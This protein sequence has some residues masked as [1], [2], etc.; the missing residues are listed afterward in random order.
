MLTA[1]RVPICVPVCEESLSQ[2]ELAVERAAAA[3]DLIEL[4][5]D[6]LRS[7]VEGD[8]ATLEKLLASEYDF[9]VTLRPVEQGGVRELDIPSRLKFWKSRWHDRAKFLDIE[10]DLCTNPALLRHDEAPD[11]SRVICS[12]HDFSGVPV[13]LDNIYEQMSATPARVLK[14]AVQARDI[15]D[16]LPVF[17]LLDRGGSEGRAIIAIAMGNAGLLTR[18]LGPS[19]GAL[20]TY[21]AL[22]HL[23]ATAPGQTTARA[24]REIY[25]IDSLSRETLVFGLVGLPVSHS[26]SPHMHNAAF[27]V[28]GVNGVYVPLEVHDLSAFFRRMVSLRTREIDWNLRG[29]SITA[30]YKSAVMDYLD[31]IEPAAKRIGAVNTVLVN[32]DGLHG[33]NLDGNA[34]I[35]ALE[36][37]FGQLR[38]ASCAL[39]GTGGVARAAIHALTKRQVKVTVYARNKIR[40]RELAEQFGGCWET[41]ASADFSKFDLVVN[42]TP[43][44]TLGPMQQL[45]PATAGQLRGARFAYDLVYNPD[46]TRFIQEARAAGCETL[47][48]L[49]MLINQACEQFR[50]W[51]GVEPPNEVM[52]AAAVGALERKSNV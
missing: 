14:I 15:T 32:S 12:H 26:V 19:R 44:G 46:D 38:G 51:T 23:H 3:A 28:A 40:A 17:S 4:R 31:W 24:L 5:L 36:E 2:M 47:S 13:N 29:L 6:Y 43:L 50:L 30:P 20:L 34:L 7:E 41:L 9:V 11:W 22:D 8:F 42:A 1:A 25:R 37:K 10:L 27:S 49:S 35:Q 21:G 48:G 52:R 45:T 18:I 33:F 16:C 39:I